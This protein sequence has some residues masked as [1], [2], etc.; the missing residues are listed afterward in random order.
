[1]TEVI[2]LPQLGTCV[3]SIMYCEDLLATKGLCRPFHVLMLHSLRHP[4][5]LN[6]LSF[7]DQIRRGWRRGD[8]FSSLFGYMKAWCRLF[9]L[10]LLHFSSLGQ[11]ATS[12]QRQHVRIYAFLWTNSRHQKSQENNRGLTLQLFHV[13]W[14][15]RG[16]YCAKC[17]Y[18][19][20][21]YK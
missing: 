19:Y 2:W 11:F 10:A 13:L 1:M 5:R 8:P 9:P 17:P 21:T 3:G 6:L 14:Q 4:W 20:L 12:Y 18:V 16:C 15:W 7:L